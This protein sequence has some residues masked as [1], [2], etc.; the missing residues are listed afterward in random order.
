MAKLRVAMTV[1][2]FRG[3]VAGGSWSSALSSGDSFLLRLVDGCGR[4]LTVRRRLRV[5]GPVAEA[6]ECA[7][8]D[9]VSSSK[10][11][12]VD[13]SA[14]TP[15]LLLGRSSDIAL[16]PAAV[17]TEWLRRDS[18]AVDETTLWGL[19]ARAFARRLLVLVFDTGSV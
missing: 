6:P 2:L 9:S 14:F 10:L 18:S 3:G 8:T 17:P 13:G 1:L 7:V 5:L 16:I 19:P 11:A 12:G 4:E 15:F